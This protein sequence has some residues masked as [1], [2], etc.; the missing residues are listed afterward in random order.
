MLTIDPYWKNDLTEQRT[1][2]IA[3]LSKG[4]NAYHA[5]IKPFIENAPNAHY[6]YFVFHINRFYSPKSS[7][8][9]PEIECVDLTREKNYRKLLNQ[10]NIDIVLS[11]NPGNIF[12]LFF[13]SI[14]KKESI[15]TVYFQ[16]GIQLD[17]TSFDPKILNRG[18]TL[19]KRF[20]S[21]HKYL[22]FYVTI[23]YNVFLN[24][25]PLSLLKTVWI[26]SRYLLKGKKSTIPKYGLKTD[27]CN[28]AF[29]YGKLDKEYL[30]NSMEMESH[31]IIISGYPFIEPEPIGLP[32]VDTSGKQFLYISSALRQVGVIPISVEEEMAFYRALKKQLNSVGY[33]LVIKLHPQEDI[34]IFE[35]YLVQ[36]SNLTLHHNTNLAELTKRADIVAGDYSTALFYAIKYY[37]PIVIIQTEYFNSYPFDFTDFGIGVKAEIDDINSILSNGIEIDKSSYDSFLR[38]YLSSTNGKSLYWNFYDQIHTQN[39]AAKRLFT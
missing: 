26:K 14:C 23:F 33:R 25:A 28:Y 37:K 2:N 29:V 35:N 15:Q 7:I 30:V 20:D 19:Q 1:I 5:H 6:R 3:F 31:N 12:E 24:K 9:N 36:D 10:H 11:Y 39:M 32:N 4:L 16:H 18:N 27:H 34:S 17:F 22:F 38:N 21:I 8:T 13:L